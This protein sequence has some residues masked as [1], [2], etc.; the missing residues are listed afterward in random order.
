MLAKLGRVD[1]ALKASEK[2]I[3]LKPDNENALYNNACINSLKGNKEKVLSVLKRAIELDKSYKEKAKKDKD[4]KKL[5]DDD[6]F[7]KLVA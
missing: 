5:R 2:A 6:D 3:E 7:K 1:E 4:F